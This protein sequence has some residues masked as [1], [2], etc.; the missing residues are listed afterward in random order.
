MENY[1]LSRLPKNLTTLK[2]GK[3]QNLT[4]GYSEAQFYKINNVYIEIYGFP[5]YDKANKESEKIEKKVLCGITGRYLFLVY[6]D[7]D[8]SDTHHYMNSVA[9]NLAG[10][11]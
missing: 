7:S 6:S 8:D 9:S 5:N 2:E 11:E 4:N 10:G 1:I 3:F